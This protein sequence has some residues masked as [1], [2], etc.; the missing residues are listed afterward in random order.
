VAVLDRNRGPRKF[1]RITG[2]AL[3]ELLPAD[4]GEPPSEPAPADTPRHDE[5]DAPADA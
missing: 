1:K 4:H 3:T 5:G 2:L